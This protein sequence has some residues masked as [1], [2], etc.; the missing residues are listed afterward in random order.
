MIVPMLKYSFLIYHKELGTFTQSLMGLGLVHVLERENAPTEEIKTIADRLR[1]AETVLKGLEKRKIKG[2]IAAKDLHESTF[3]KINAFTEKEKQ[4]EKINRARDL[5]LSEIKLLKPWVEVPWKLLKKLEQDAGITTRFFE[6]P[7]RKFDKTW[8]DDH[9]IEIL[10]EQNGNTYFILLHRK[11][12][13]AIPLV[14]LV[15]PKKSLQELT[16]KLKELDAEI[17]VLNGVLDEYAKKYT[18]Y[19]K[20]RID[21]IRDK[22]A[23][24]TAEVQTENAAEDHLTLLEAWCPKSSTKGLD[25]Y[26]E[27]ENI[28][29]VIQA[30]KEDEVPPVL[31]KNNAFTKLFEP[32]G[33]MF[34]LPAYSELDLTVYFAPF[35]LLFFGFCLGDMGYGVVIMLLTTLL[36]PKYKDNQEVKSILTLGQLFGL[37]TT[38]I[39]FFSGTLFGLEMVN[40][41]QFEA[42]KY[43]FISQDNM[44]FVAL[45]IGFFQIIFGM[46]VQ[47]YKQVKFFGWLYALNRIGWII[48]LPALIDVIGFKQFPQISLIGLILGGALIVLFGSPKDGPLKSIGLGIADLYNVTGFAGDL[49]S[50]IRLFALGVSSAIL[51]LV[52]NSIALSAKGVPYVGIVLTILILVVG[53][54]ANLMLA[55]LSAF[56]HPMRLTFVEFYKNVG[57]LGGGVPFKKFHKKYQSIKSKKE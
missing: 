24:T 55:S 32:I 15:L 34:S 26:L 5:I 25:K 9:A 50:Y 23:L 6:Y 42:V 52:V 4:L 33:K 36:K 38:I 29:H 56:V 30:P 13:K 7:T 8:Q 27:N 28:V 39:G 2:R 21:A 19:L 44:F 45:G 54:S 37:S 20:H 17:I 51:G 57:F 48:A 35:F 43:L 49:L 3:P 47:V 22:L 53:H 41:T 11:D 31:L 16:V 14:P 40:L 12:Y 1:N 10:N 18:Y 46:C